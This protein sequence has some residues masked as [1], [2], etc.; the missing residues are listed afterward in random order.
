MCRLLCVVLQATIPG[1]CP[2]IVSGVHYVFAIARVGSL[3]NPQWE[4]VGVK[5][6]FTVA[7]VAYECGGVFCAGTSASSVLTQEVREGFCEWMFFIWS[8]SSE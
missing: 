4:I 8:S 2:S 7:D 1:T 3:A 5:R 6:S